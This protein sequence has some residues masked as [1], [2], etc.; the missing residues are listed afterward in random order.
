MFKHRLVRPLVTACLA[1]ALCAVA[2]QARAQ[3]L[4]IK[5][6]YGMMAGTQA[7]P[8]V[9]AGMFGA[10]FA[11]PTRSGAPTATPSRD[12]T[13]R[14]R[15]FG[16]LVMYVSN[17][18]ILGG[19]YG[20]VV[21]RSL[22]EHSDRLSAPRHRRRLDRPRAVAALRLSLPDR[23]ALGQEDADLRRRHG[24]PL[25]VHLL[26]ADRPLHAGRAE[27]HLARDVVQRALAAGHGL[28]RQ[29]EAVACRRRPLLRHQ[30]Q[31]GRR[32]LEA[33]QRH[34]LHVGRRPQLVRAGT[35]SSAAGS[36]S[37]ATRSGR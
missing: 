26:R 37:R 25:R 11:G 24:R 22:R 21:G 33:G 10:H 8:G 17:L 20:A 18:K 30:Q 1:L 19:N 28:R 7:P 13:S 27:Q 31:E 12:P 36:A 34:Q 5:G 14:R 2:P 9:Y 4:I 6:M 15:L 23:V 35:A 32:R 3:Q 29:G 16:P